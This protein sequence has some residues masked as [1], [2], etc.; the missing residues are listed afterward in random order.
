M[1]Y[2]ERT[3][4]RAVSRGVG[5]AIGNAVRQAV[6]PQA[7]QFVNQTAQQL[8]QQTGQTY[9][10]QS[11]MQGAFSGLEQAAQNYATAAAKNVKV[12]PN[13][14][15]TATADKKFCPECGCQLPEQSL[16]QAAVCTACGTQNNLGTKFCTACGA[17]L[18]IA[19]Q[20]EQ[21]QQRKLENAM[22]QWDQLLPQYPKWCC[23]GTNISI[24][25]YDPENLAVYVTFQNNPYA[26]RQ[27]V[28]Q[29]RQILLQNGFRMAG[30][31]PS[32]EQLFARIGDAVYNVDTEHCFEG[33][34]D[35]ACIGF[36]RREPYGGFDYVKPEPRR[37]TGLKDLF[38]F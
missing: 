10:P 5:N 15:A 32:M 26:A 13:C 9:A 34:A 28:E 18:P 30:Q 36:C 35:T 33:D 21:R 25:Q 31:Y 19:L 6:E 23:G 12:C 22:A 37:K 11:N 20:E 2:L 24:E 17:K 14:D 29:Y 1:S 38:G 3:L 27:A 8:N 4:R 16:A 7:T